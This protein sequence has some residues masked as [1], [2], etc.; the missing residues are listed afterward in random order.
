MRGDVRRVAAVVKRQPAEPVEAT[1]NGGGPS[2]ERA[3][4]VIED[5][6]PVRR[7]HV[8]P[9]RLFQRV[10]ANAGAR[11][12]GRRARMTAKGPPPMNAP[13]KLK[14]VT[15]PDFLSARSRGA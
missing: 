8:S 7:F 14:P 9:L 1:Q 11:S 3:V 13:S 15:V 12:P 2:A 6:G 10:T 4:A 5:D